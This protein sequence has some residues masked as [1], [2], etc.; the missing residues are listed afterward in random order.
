M[1]KT[2]TID[3]DVAVQLDRLR[4]E[5]DASLKELVNEGL[6][7]W[8]HGMNAPPKPRKPVK[9]RVFDAGEPLIKNLDNIGEV[10]ALIEGEDYR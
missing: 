5:R 1:R 2:M 10:L 9:L 8:L 7:S 3:D 6:R 4:K